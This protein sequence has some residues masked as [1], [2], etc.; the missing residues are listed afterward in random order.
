MWAILFG[1]VEFGLVYWGISALLGSGKKTK[2]TQHYTNF[3]GDRVHDVTYHDSGRRV[4]HVTGHNIFGGKVTTTYELEKGSK[5]CF[6]CQSMVAPD[7]NGAYH[8]CGRTFY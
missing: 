8:C 7:S 6:R 4:K 2:T 3:F 1:A 5:K